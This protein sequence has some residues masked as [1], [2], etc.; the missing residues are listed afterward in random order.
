MPTWTGAKNSSLHVHEYQKKAAHP[1]T[2]NRNTPA[3]ICDLRMTANVQAHAQPLAAD[4]E[5]KGNL[6]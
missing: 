4:V 6:E 3:I 1:T 5:R 2:I